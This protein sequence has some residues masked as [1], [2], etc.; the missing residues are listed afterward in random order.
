MKRSMLTRGLIVATV[1]MAALVLGACSE[2]RSSTEAN[3]PAMVDHAKT[4]AQRTLDMFRKTDPTLDRFF[5]SA[6]GYAVFPEIA[7]GAAGIGA[8]HGTGVV[9]ENGQAV[10]TASMTQ[11]TLGL[12]LGGQTYSELI[13]FEDAHALNTFKASETEFSA[14]ASAVAAAKGAAS[15]A[16]YS[17]GVAIFTSGQ[18]GLM[19]EA[20][21]GG[22]KFNYTPYK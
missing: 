5:K 13:F 6:V 11:G 18:Q 14:Q 19:F 15:N 22:Q 3:S 4:E 12:Q 16:D 21:V 9:Y 17:N 8:A 2:Y 10:G 20:S 1:S 7:K